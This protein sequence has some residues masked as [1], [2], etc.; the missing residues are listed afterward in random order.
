MI[1][2]L[3]DKDDVEVYKKVVESFDDC[4]E[5][6]DYIIVFDISEKDIAEKIVDRLEVCKNVTYEVDD[7]T[8]FIVVYH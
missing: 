3:T 7:G 2:I 4:L 8:E 1:K 5:D 6:W